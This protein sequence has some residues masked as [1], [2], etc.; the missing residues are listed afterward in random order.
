MARFGQDK[1]YVLIPQFFSGK[2]VYGDV[3]LG[4]P[5]IKFLSR[6]YAQKRIAL[7]AD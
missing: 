3:L 7:L 5:T 2:L 4:N 1:Y 6:R